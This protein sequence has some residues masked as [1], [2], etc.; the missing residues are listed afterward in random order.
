MSNAMI[1]RRLTH[2]KKDSPKSIGWRKM[3]EKMYMYYFSLTGG[4]KTA[5]NIFTTVFGKK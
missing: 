1:N 3:A 4:T 5:S 2:S